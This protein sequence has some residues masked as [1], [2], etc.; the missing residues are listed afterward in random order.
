[1]IYI[2]GAPVTGGARGGDMV[3]NPVNTTIKA[4]LMISA[5]RRGQATTKSKQSGAAVCR[6][7]RAAAL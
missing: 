6:L 5:I 1:M 4:W 3:D 7:R 2:G